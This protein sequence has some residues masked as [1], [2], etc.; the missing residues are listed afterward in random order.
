MGKSLQELGLKDEPLP[1]A[2]QDLS[3]LPEFGTFRE[4]PQPGPFRFKLPTDLN[5]IWDVYDTPSKVPP[6]RVRAIFDRDHPL[7]IVQSVGGRYNNEPFETRVS[8]EERNR[9]KGGVI[10]SDMDYILRALGFKQKPP[11]N[12]AYIELMKQQAG[13]EFGADIRYSWKC[14][15]DR[16]IRVLDPAGQVREVEGRKGCDNAYY[17]EDVPNG[18]KDA[19]GNVT[20]QIT[21]Q[22]GALLRCFANLDNIRP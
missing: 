7:Q 13:K 12:K 20:T 22:C 10:A 18:G 2:G 6:Q 14:S 8:N 5:T 1:T 15:K 9:G 21:C 19:S 16:N 17:Q 3:D 4:P 11:S